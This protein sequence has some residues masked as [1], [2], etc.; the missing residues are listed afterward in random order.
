MSIAQWVGL[1]AASVLALVIVFQVLLAMGRPLGAAAWGGRH[2]V[3][4][5]R[6]RWASLASAGV[7]ALMT[8]VALARAD[9]VGPGSGPFVTRAATW[10]C[11]CL[12]LVNTIGNAA[13]TSPTERRI[14]TPTTLL[15]AISF[16]ALA[17][18]PA[19]PGAPS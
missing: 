11:A 13:S 15:L 9:L 3:L 5:P 6:L 8:W 14:M 1:L 7:L 2:V 16:V 19:E 10:L 12:L 4:P 17:T 18:S